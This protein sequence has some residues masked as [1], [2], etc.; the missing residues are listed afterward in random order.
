MS[1]LVLQYSHFDVKRLTEM[2][3]RHKLQISSR[4]SALF[5]ILTSHQCSAACAGFESDETEDGIL[6]T[7]T[8][9]KWFDLQQIL[10]D[11][12]TAPGYITCK[13]SDV[14]KFVASYNF[15]DVN[16][17][18]TLADI[19][20]ADADR[21]KPALKRAISLHVCSAACPTYLLCS[22]G[23]FMPD[24][25]PFGTTSPLAIPPSHA[26]HS[27]CTVTDLN[28]LPVLINNNIQVDASDGRAH[29]NTYLLNCSYNFVEIVSPVSLQTLVADVG[30][31]FI[32]V[33]TTSISDLV[34]MYEYFTKAQCQQPKR[35]WP[36]SIAR[37]AYVLTS[38]VGKTRAS[39]DVNPYES[40]Q[41]TTVYPGCLS[42]LETFF[43]LLHV[44]ERELD[45]AFILVEAI[46]R[47]SR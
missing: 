40:M 24:P 20:G 30:V 9:N 15:L 10:Q 18:T 33:H 25:A 12:T 26:Q 21:S 22:P 1:Q 31:K 29:A 37:V 35:G 42:T 3:H 38:F 13:L 14:Q 34:S 45:H 23:G 36:S 44:R 4:K 11:G 2:A 5:A 7:F 27:S 28:V 39:G 43:L 41:L 8:L 46:D 6:S 32:A 47:V 17:L 19:H 16:Q